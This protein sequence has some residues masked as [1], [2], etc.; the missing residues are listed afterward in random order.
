MVFYN[1]FVFFL[2]WV[3][4]KPL[5]SFLIHKHQQWEEFLSTFSVFV[6]IKINPNE[7]FIHI[8][9]PVHNKW[10]LLGLF[11]MV[12]TYYFLLK[13]LSP[14]RTHHFNTKQIHCH[15]IV[16]TRLYAIRFV[17]NE[18]LFYFSMSFTPI[19]KSNAYPNL[20]N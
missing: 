19:R 17:H 2:Y 15:L 12:F 1:D 9:S 3:A 8:N 20:H 5:L 6:W 7:K 13:C 10:F 16:F 14:R 18:K 4:C 11:W